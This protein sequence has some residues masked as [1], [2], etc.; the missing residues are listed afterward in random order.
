VCGRYWLVTPADVLASRFR[1]RGERIPLLPR[2]NAAPGQDLP[3]VR[4][5]PRVRGARVLEPMRWGLVPSWAGGPED[6]G[7]PINARAESAATKPTFKE[8]LRS[9]R[10]LVPADGFF[11][12]KKGDRGGE[13]FAIR[14]KSRRT[15]A[16]A[17]LFDEWKPRGGPVQRTFAILTTR[18]ND[19]VGALHDRMPVILSPEGETLWLD[20]DVRD[21]AQLAPLFEP[22]DADSMEAF[23]VSRHVNAPAH[24]DPSVLEPPVPEAPRPPKA[25]KNRM[26]QRSL[27]ENDDDDESDDAG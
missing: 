18:P 2:W 5:D 26:S 25:R 24:D 4:L 17:G 23:P 12:W 13:P 14:L 11:E 7:R 9:R 10:A 15:F 8:P 6:A 1:L 19:L 3:V 21:P 20:P 27:W 16:F 22:S